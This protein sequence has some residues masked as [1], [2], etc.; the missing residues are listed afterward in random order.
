MSDILTEV[1]KRLQITGDY[2]DEMLESWIDTCK[3]YLVNGGGSTEDIETPS[4]YGVIAQG[5]Y[6]MWTNKEFSSIFRDM[7]VNW[8]LSHPSPSES[9]IF[10]AEL[11]TDDDIDRL[12]ADIYEKENEG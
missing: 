4:A 2:Q 3:K 9:E 12:F 11:A 8:I 1:K 7:A 10:G 5:V 6:D